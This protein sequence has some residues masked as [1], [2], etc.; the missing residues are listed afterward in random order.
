MV[1]DTNATTVHRSSEH[2]IRDSEQTTCCVVGGGPAGMIL[3]YLLARQQ[4]PVILLE[5]HKDF[6][7]DF[8]GDTIHPSVME[9]LDELGL[10]ERLLQLRHTKIRNIALPTGNGSA[11][12]ID[13]SP[14]KI[15]YPYVTLMPQSEFLDFM[16]AEAQRLPHF[17]LIMGGRVEELIDEGGVVR[18]VRYQSG[19]GWHEIRATLTVGA[20]GRFS[21]LRRLSG[22]EAIT[23]SPPMDVLWFRLPRLATEPEGAMA[24]VKPGRLMA[25]LDRREQWQI[26]YVIP[27][28]SFRELKE[29]GIQALRQSIVELAPE[30][31]DR[32]DG[33]QD[34][35]QVALLSVAADR[36]RQWYKPGLL[37]IGDAAHTMSPVGGVGINY[38]IQDAVATANILTAPLQTGRLRLSDLRAVQR[39]RELPTRFIQT[40]QSII[41]QRV[42]SSLL[43]SRAQP[44]LPGLVLWLVQFRFVRSIPARVMG[45]GLRPEHVQQRHEIATTAPR[46]A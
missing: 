3:A 2:E 9:N 44:K 46:P 36:L 5:A 11:T 34:W 4:V 31:A 24:R 15:K 38:A 29:A 8:R 12:P 45:I 25:M 32:V 17:K 7:R 37:L 27:K 19:D 39:R 16:A 10:A 6:D 23:T 22:L 33:L 40:I 1:L 42:I 35:K 30:L 14:L 20:D 18:G 28:D 43:D 21:R 41:Q 13:F 26:A